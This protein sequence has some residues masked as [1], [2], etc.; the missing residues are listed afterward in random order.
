MRQAAQFV[1]FDRVLADMGYDAEANHRLCREELRIRS[2]VIPVNRRRTR[3]WPRAKYRRQ[4]RRRFPNRVYGGRAQVE[5]VI[6]RN[7]RRLG[8]ALRA[9][10][11]E[12]QAR[13][14]LMRVLTHNIMILCV[15]S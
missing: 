9:R 7:K 14:S 13:E 10:K 1:S 5:S 3:K 6:S 15:R 12:A 2:S 4:M 11:P 8:S